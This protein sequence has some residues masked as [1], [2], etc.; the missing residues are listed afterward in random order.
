MRHVLL[1]VDVEALPAR[2]ERD[3]VERLVYGRFPGTASLGLR[4]L[5]TAAERSGHSLTCFFDYCEH[6]LY[7]DSFLS[8]AREIDDR[9]HSLQ[10]HAHPEVMTPKTRARLGLSELPR[11]LNEFTEQE[12]DRLFD[13]LLDLHLKVT[14]KP[15]VAFRGGGY[16]YGANVLEAMR[17]HGLTVSSNHNP[18]RADQFDTRDSCASFLHDSGIFEY[19]ISVLYQEDRRFEFNF[20]Q[21]RFAKT[22]KWFP[23]AFWNEYGDRATLNL[24]AHSKSLLVIDAQ[25]R[26]FV[27]GGDASLRLFRQLLAQLRT[28]QFKAVVPEQLG[29]AARLSAQH[30][31]G[32]TQD[33][34]ADCAVAPPSRVA[35]DAALS[36]NFATAETSRP[37]AAEPA[38]SAAPNVVCPVCNHPKGRFT[39]RNNRALARCAGCGALERQR[40]L[41]QAW[42]ASLRFDVATQG[43]AALMVAPARSERMFFSKLGFGSLRSLDIRPD[44]ACDIVADLC[45]M[46]QIADASFDLV[47][48]SHVL[49]RLHDLPAALG[50]IARILTTEGVFLSFTPVRQGQPTTKTAGSETAGWYGEDL[51]EKHQVGT[52]RRFGD[53]GLLRDLQRHF[54]VKTVSGVDPVTGRTFV[55]TC[56]WKHAAADLVR[57]LPA[58]PPRY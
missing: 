50:E 1:T 47:F 14:T 30:R 24:V 43:R 12:A 21:A 20:N 33:I 58:R 38:P 53:L 40:S 11:L 36:P 13:W 8:V 4:E 26:F 17:R 55:W 57:A 25:R 46:P 23:Q 3:H 5:M 56:A 37:E 28:D 54:L 16:R 6:D 31:F 34:S 51:L 15:P 7:G 42:N 49:P 10:L 48:A 41:V 29:D 18:G 27:P 22:A 2:A 32:A 44:A 35:A 9:G 45:A 39:E 52:F 19:P